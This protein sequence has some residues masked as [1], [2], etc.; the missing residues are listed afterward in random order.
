MVMV[1]PNGTTVGLKMLD[2][3][4]RASTIVAATL[5]ARAGALSSDD[6]ASLAEAL[7]LTVLGGG[8]SVGRIRPGNGI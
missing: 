2:G 5:L 8:E 1:A 7:P 3:A 6:V 4:A